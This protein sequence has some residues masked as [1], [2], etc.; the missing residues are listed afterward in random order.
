MREVHGKPFLCTELRYTELRKAFPDKLKT[1]SEQKKKK[2]GP[3]KFKIRHDS[4]YSDGS[5]RRLSPTI[6]QLKPPGQ[7][8]V[9]FGPLPR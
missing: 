6:S 3:V 7:G 5:K 1:V 2:N 8:K 4:L 9:E